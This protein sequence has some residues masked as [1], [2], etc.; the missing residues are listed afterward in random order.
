MTDK[1][2]STANTNGTIEFDTP[3]NGQIGALGIRIPIR[4]HIYYASRAGE[5]VPGT[6]GPDTA[7]PSMSPLP[8][9]FAEKMPS[10][11]DN[12]NAPILLIIGRYNGHPATFRR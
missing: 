3:P 9:H 1:Y 11:I 8:I 5:I 4:A 6:H 2:P 7:T 10:R 12:L